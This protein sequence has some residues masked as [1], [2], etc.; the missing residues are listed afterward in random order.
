MKYIILLV[1]I[2][3]CGVKHEHTIKGFDGT[4]VNFGPNFN[5]A[6]NI[7]DNRYGYKTKESEDCF[8]DYRDYTSIKIVLDLSGIEEFC[9]KT[10]I[11]Q[12]EV[13]ACAQDL[14][15]ILTKVTRTAE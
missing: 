12:E 5:D 6:A 2:I 9:N 14:L 10:Y 3:S 4:S 7:C 13:T 11:D 8:K 1:L 15:E